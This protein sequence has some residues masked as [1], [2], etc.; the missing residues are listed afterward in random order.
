LGALYAS[1]EVDVSEPHRRAAELFKMACEDDDLRA[2]VRLGRMLQGDWQVSIETPSA[3]DLFERACDGGHAGACD[4]LDA[5]GADQ[6]SSSGTSGESD[7]QGEHLTTDK[8][9]GASG[10]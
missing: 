3:R 7:P 2:C 9:P 5:L 4:E 10:K 1:G 6:N 8:P